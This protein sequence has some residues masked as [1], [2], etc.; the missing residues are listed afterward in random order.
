MKEEIVGKLRIKVIALFLFLTAGIFLF[1]HF[2]WYNYFIHKKL[3]LE[4]IRSFHL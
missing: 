4:L 2:S 3:A 1:I